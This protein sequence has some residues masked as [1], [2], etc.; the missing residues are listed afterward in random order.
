MNQE[1]KVPSDT[2]KQ[3]SG[4]QTKDIS[5]VEPGEIPAAPA[6]LQNCKAHF[7]RYTSE[8]ESKYLQQSAKRDAWSS[9]SQWF[10]PA[11]LLAA[12]SL[13]YWLLRHRSET[14]LQG[15]YNP[16]EFRT[17]VE[18]TF[19]F[20]VVLLHIALAAYLLKLLRMLRYFSKKSSGGD[21]AH[22]ADKTQGL[23][24]GPTNL[25]SQAS[26]KEE[27]RHPI[28]RIEGDPE[29]MLRLVL[30]SRSGLR[31][32][33]CHYYLGEIPLTP[34]PQQRGGLPLHVQKKSRKDLSQTDLEELAKIFPDQDWLLLSLECRRLS[35][36]FR[37]DVVRVQYYDFCFFYLCAIDPIP[38]KHYRKNADGGTARAASDGP[39]LAGAMRLIEQWSIPSLHDEDYLIVP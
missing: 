1:E 30:T 26:R 36:N 16:G 29:E 21:A 5:P 2:Q 12:L 38:A 9:L 10:F 11:L 3:V 31:R 32:Y 8:A 7:Q 28:F 22:V 24:N 23:A 25:A 39:E 33:R 17:V 18:F 20:F 34:L 15:I 14:L 35:S 19:K 4:A 37:A 27:G 6:G 13:G